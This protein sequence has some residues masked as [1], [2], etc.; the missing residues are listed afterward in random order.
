MP[1]FLIL[2]NFCPS[3]TVK[4]PGTQGDEGTT[5]FPEPGFPGLQPPGKRHTPCPPLSAP[6]SAS[7]GLRT[8]LWH[9]GVEVWMQ[10][11]PPNAGQRSFT[12]VTLSPGSQVRWHM[13]Y[14]YPGHSAVPGSLSV[15][16]GCKLP[17]V[18]SFLKNI[19]YD[20]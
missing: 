11:D 13:C 16:Q 2:C 19:Y 7:L 12:L 15:A 20:F 8:S 1:A 5:Q 18:H 6:S 10:I 14:S 9:T 3:W 4:E 17:V